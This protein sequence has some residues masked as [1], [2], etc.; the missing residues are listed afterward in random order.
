[1]HVRE[2]CCNLEEIQ[3]VGKNIPKFLEDE[4]K[5]ELLYEDPEAWPKRPLTK[6]FISQDRKIF[7][8][9]LHTRD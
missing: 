7:G 4:L 6:Y 1:M 5:G 3:C 9:M 8:Q 2:R